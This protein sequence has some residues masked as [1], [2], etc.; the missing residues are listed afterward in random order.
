MSDPFLPATAAGA[1]VHVTDL[2]IILLVGLF[3][4][5]GWRRGFLAGALGLLRLTLAVVAGLTWYPGVEDWI[6]RLGAWLP[7]WNRPIAFIGVVLVTGTLVDLLGGMVLRR[8]PPPVHTSPVNRLLGV[9]PGLLSGALYAVILVA[10][11]F[12]LPL[13]ASARENLRGSR[14]APPLSDIAQR[15]E[16]TLEPVFGPAL[17]SLQPKSTAGR[18]VKLPFTVQDA[19]PVPLFEAQMLDLMNA[20]RAEAGLRPLRPDPEMRAVARRHSADMFARG[21]FAHTTPE[22]A[23]P[24]DR[25]RRARVRYFMAGENLALAPT[26]Q[27]AHTNLMNSPGHRANILHP[28]FGRVGIGILDGGFR[29]LMVT[30]KFR[31]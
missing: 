3:A 20:A 8:L 22:G 7:T 16:R 6:G 14:L 25:M 2:L 19:P 12:T 18:Q 10:V 30:Q 27:I 5:T 26:V 29:G 21:Y 1:V 28:G 23:S 31:N 11:A 24:F 13:P 4:W 17:I 9:I 15:A